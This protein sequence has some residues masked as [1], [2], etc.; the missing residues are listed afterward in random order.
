MECRKV[1]TDSGPR[2]SFS[3]GRAEIGKKPLLIIG[4][5]SVENR[6]MIIKVA[7]FVSMQIIDKL[8]VKNIV[9]RG[10]VWKPRT[11]PYSFQGVGEDALVWLREAG[12]IYGLPVIAEVL[13]PRQVEVADKYLHGFW[14]GARNMQNTPLLKELALYNKPVL[15]KRYFGAMIN[16]W[17]CAAEYLL[18]GGNSKVGL[19]ER[20][21]RGLNEYTRFSLDVT[22]IPVIKKISRLPIIVDVSHPAGY[23]EYVPALAAASLAAGADGLM[24][25]VHPNPANALS[26][27]HQQLTFQELNSVVLDLLRMRLL[28]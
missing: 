14:V 17:L 19:I 9:L 13:D 11:S 25:E 28:A 23:H 12:D 16:E 1:L 15:L 5:C 27:K 6:E 22:V 7:E 26:D 24:V 10:G 3:I 20:G 4:P 2:L 18:A 21:T 8:G